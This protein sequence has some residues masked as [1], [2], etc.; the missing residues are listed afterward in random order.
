MQWFWE[1]FDQPTDP[2]MECDWGDDKGLS[3]DGEPFNM[4]YPT[5]G[6]RIYKIPYDYAKHNEYT[7][8]CKMWNHVS[9]MTIIQDV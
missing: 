7:Y 9:N 2:L 3:P 5:N 1:Q 4:T 6:T 8:T